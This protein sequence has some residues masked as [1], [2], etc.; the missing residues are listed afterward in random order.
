MKF[1][2]VLFDFDGTLM[3]T[4]EGIFHCA[5][6]TMAELGK[7]V[8]PDV[9]MNLFV[10][11]P[12][13]DCFRIT[14]GLEEGLID[15]ACQI[16]RRHYGTVGKY[17]AKFYPHVIEALNTLHDAGIPLAITTMKASFL[18]GEIA[19]HFGF[20]SLIDAVFGA[21]LKGSC[22]KKDLV[23]AACSHFGA[24]DL[25]RVILV[26]D[27]MLDANGAREAGVDFLGVSFGFGEFT[28]EQKAGFSHPLLDDYCHLPQLVM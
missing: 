23:E 1:D 19:E 27:T 28:E 8:A 13:G 6:Q 17:E 22:T 24:R 15:Q 7:T 12:L 21:D 2:L 4:S 10:G 26:G 11:P 9:N 14:F 18:A 20:K 5:R 16:Y 3:D 25:S